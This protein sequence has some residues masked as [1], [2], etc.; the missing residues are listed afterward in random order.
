MGSGLSA[1]AHYSKLAEPANPVMALEGQ[2]WKRI[3]AN[4]NIMILDIAEPNA[5]ELEIWSYSPDLFAKKR[6]V[7]LFSLY[8]S[9]RE[10]NDERVQSALV[11]MMEQVEW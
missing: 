5:Y 3:K 2:Q 10:D 11:E 1:L 4:D 9:M 6:V 8:L 7:D